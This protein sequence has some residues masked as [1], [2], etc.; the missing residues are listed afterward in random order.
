MR[1][2]KIKQSGFSHWLFPIAGIIWFLGAL[3]AITWVGESKFKEFDPSL[4]LSSEMM[5]LSMEDELVAVLN[6]PKSPVDFKNNDFAGRILHV[7]QGECFCETLSEAHQNTLNQWAETKNI[8]FQTIQIASLAALTRF[9]P[10]TPA[11]IVLNKNNDL[12]Y[13]GPYS[14]G[15]GCFQDSGLVDERIRPYFDEVN[16]VAALSEVRA[17]IQS[18][19]KGCYCP[20]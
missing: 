19:A 18:E 6:N 10:S 7:V 13:L 20:T 16:G 5:S 12:V 14:T 17:A 1:S 9:V 8:H 3:F 2:F 11:V 15:M 4:R